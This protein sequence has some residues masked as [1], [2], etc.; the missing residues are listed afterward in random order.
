M[1]LSRLGVL[2]V[3]SALALA[4]CATGKKAD[5]DMPSD[6]KV[7]GTL[8]INGK[9]FPLKH[10]YAG[11][12]TEGPGGRLDVLVTNE[13]ISYEALSRIFLE[14]EVSF[15]RREKAKVLKGTSL[16]ALYFAVDSYELEQAGRPSY[17]AEP[18]KVTFEGM[19]MTSDTFSGYSQFSPTTQFDEFKYKEG[20]IA[21]TA[22][23]KW[24]QTETG[25]DVKDI[26]IDA[27]FSVSFEAKD[28]DQS[29]LSRSLSS[30]NKS[31]QESLSRLPDEGKSQG[32]VTMSGRVIDLEYAYAMKEKEGNL[33]GV[34]TV[35]L[36]DE[37]VRKEF[38][39]LSFERGLVGDGYG[40]R[41]RFD[42]SGNV[43]ESFV[44]HPQQ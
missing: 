2:I 19:L 14:L 13:P 15:L 40:L 29:L 3:A 25:E 34:T 44:T 22:K 5:A 9:N 1:N 28:S 37:P 35:L 12:E 4:G 18:S 36:T 32:T 11:L 10:V 41:L 23:H 42:E 6:G 31:W 39:L 38:L 8:T 21:A 43:L 7:E 16:K 17:T 33:K 27:S 24:K 30:E 20:T 26:K